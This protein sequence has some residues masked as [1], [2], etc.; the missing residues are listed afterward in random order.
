[1]KRTRVLGMRGVDAGQALEIGSLIRKM[2]HRMCIEV[3]ELARISSISEQRIYRIEAGDVEK[4]SFEAV[5]R[6]LMAMGIRI[7]LSIAVSGVP[8]GSFNNLLIRGDSIAVKSKAKYKPRQFIKGKKGELWR[9]IKFMRH[10]IKR[11]KAEDVLGAPI[12]L[13][14]DTKWSK[15]EDW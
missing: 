5:E 11:V 8:E 2:R 13:T 7:T 3:K 15:G 1:M 14:E 12:K 4:P 6:L 10:G 9:K